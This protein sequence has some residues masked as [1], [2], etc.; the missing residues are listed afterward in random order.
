MKH[1]LQRARAHVPHYRASQLPG[2]VEHSDA[3]EA[4]ARTLD[5]IQPL[6]KETYAA[7]P[8][9]FLAEDISPRRLRRGKTSGTTGTA[10]PLWYTLETLAEEY[11]TVW[12]AR[13]REGVRLGDPHFSF[14]GQL[15]VPFE[16]QKPPFWRHNAFGR[17]TLFSLYHM[18]PSNLPLYVDALHEIPARYAQ[19]YPSSLF[20]LANE[21]LRL[22]RPLPEGKLAAVFT[23]SESLLAFHRQVIQE[24][25]GAPVRDRYGTSEF[26]VS[27]TECS[28]GR[29]HVDSEFCVV[30]IE[31]QD[32]SCEWERGPLLVTGLAND[33]TPFIRYRVGDVGTR[34]KASCSCGLQG[35]VF[36]DIDGRVEDY[37]VTPDRRSIG[38]LDHI[39]KDQVRVAE[40]QILQDREGAIRML[41]VP[42]RGWDATAEESLL[43]EAR[44]RLGGEIPIAIEVVESIARETNGKFRAVKSSYER[45]KP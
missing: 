4:L 16:Q 41:V 27:M 5:R 1:L 2:P 13:E 14:G 20:L 15:I 25:F 40:G 44:L 43:R 18:T 39:F 36:I 30:E 37:V 32:T 6:E 26:C 7:D 35:D 19:G 17:Q 29:M 34:Q 33:A 28:E 8:K 9:S 11:A 24:A 21:I 45:P 23:S 38:R 31:T 3:V 42:R 22:G 12:R 10:M